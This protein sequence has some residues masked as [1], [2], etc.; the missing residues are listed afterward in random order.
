VLARVLQEHDLAETR[1]GT[2]ALT[3][4]AVDDVT[5][6][7][8]LAV[9][10][11]VVNASGA[12]S[13]LRTLALTALFVAVMLA[14]VRPLL[15]RVRTI[16]LPVAVA[17]G[18]SAAWLTETIGIHAIFGAFLAGVV[19]PSR[20]EAR[21]DL[22]G[23]LEL[24]TTTVLLPMYF[25]SVGLSTRVTLLD[26]PEVW[27]VTLAVVAVAVAGKLGGSAVAARLMGETR[28]DA[29]V[30]G[31]LM[32]T[33][34]LTEIVI[35]TVGLDLGVIDQRMFTIMVLMALVTTFMAGPL[36]RVLTRSGP[37]NEGRLAAA[38]P[39]ENGRS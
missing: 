5:A 21:G 26:T 33:R 35:L 23:G 22:A 3:C 2:L 31:V 19:M 12:A 8:A 34:G 27:A 10:V 16:P 28:H 39:H 32:N 14:A 11:A 37:R 6:W 4:A 7:C 20:Q 13:A 9:V 29:L 25:V 30:L 17:F 1:I 24:V 38:D 36:L 15:A 18:L